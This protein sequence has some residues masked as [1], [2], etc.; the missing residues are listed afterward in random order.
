MQRFTHRSIAYP[1][2]H[3]VMC[4]MLAKTLLPW[5]RHHKQPH[6]RQ[7]FTVATTPS[8]LSR[9]SRHHCRPLTPDITAE[10]STGDREPSLPTFGASD[11]PTPRPP[12][13]FQGLHPQSRNSNI[14]SSSSNDI[15]GTSLRPNIAAA[16]S[17]VSKFGRR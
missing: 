5:R 8:A 2:G 9:P 1:L 11:M 13:L 3:A 6:N 12:P 10:T 7:Q 17:S 4:A 15:G 14:S 16:A